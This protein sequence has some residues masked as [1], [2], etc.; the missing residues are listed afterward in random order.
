MA[1]LTINI[2]VYSLN[3]ERPPVTAEILD[4]EFEVRQKLVVRGA[5][6]TNLGEGTY[7]VR[8]MLPSGESLSSQVTISPG[9]SSAAVSLNS[10]S[11][12][13]EYLAWQQYLGGYRGQ[14]Q[15]LKRAPT[16]SGDLAEPQPPIDETVWL[17]MWRLG[18]RSGNVI[19]SF[20]LYERQSAWQVESLDEW[21]AHPYLDPAMPE[22]RVMW[23][24]PP[25]EMP[26][27]R[28]LQIGGQNIPWRNICLPPSRDRL[29][30][31]MRP[32]GS[33]NELNGGLAVKVVTADTET[34]ALSHYAL[35]GDFNASDGLAE[36][37][38]DKAEDL[39]R[40]KLIYPY[41]AMIGAYH[42]LLSGKLDRLHNWANN[43]ANWVD[44]LP[45]SAVIH[46]WQILY[47]GE[48]AEKSLARERLLQAAQRGLPVMRKGLRLLVD[49]LS[50]FADL[51]KQ[52][53]REDKE[54]SQALKYVRRYAGSVDWNQ[55]LTTF[56]GQTPFEPA[57]KPV[58]G[59]PPEAII[60]PESLVQLNVQI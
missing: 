15:T 23:L 25:D 51:A 52:D 38:M 58:L 60:Q 39:F 16:K 36:S 4:S 48:E 28:C 47:S 19:N 56:Y 9:Q 7:L 45:D 40:E 27:I 30:V 35:S 42:L 18:P 26:R 21:Q 6:Q 8:A 11:S 32:S 49:G 46:A 57:L 43:F 29:Q 44:W 55:R 33:G 14:D 17:R 2:N 12:P 50:I 54:V 22:V 20:Y 10:H 24:S 3:S 31:L 34:E 59:E 1:T 53:E 41:G 13:H 37:V 5:E